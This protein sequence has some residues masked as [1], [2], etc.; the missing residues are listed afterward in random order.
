MGL[1][2]NLGKLSNMITSTG[3]A[4]SISGTLTLATTQYIGNLQFGT[5]SGAS[6]GYDAGS[7]AMTYNITAGAAATSTYY[8]FL[9][10]GTSIVNILKGGNVGIGVTPNAWYTGNSSKA[11]QIGVAGVG[12]WGYG[13]TTNINTYLT[14]NAYYDSVGW[15]YAQAS[16]KASFYQ[17][18]NGLHIWSTTDTTGTAAGDVISF[19]ERMRISSTGNVAIGDTATTYG[20][21][22][23]NGYGAANSLM[24]QPVLIA[25]SGANAVQLGSDG[26]NA[27][28]GAGNSGSSLI[29]LSRQ[30]GEYAAAITITGAGVINMNT[31]SGNKL[32]TVK[33]QTG[34]GYYG[35]VRMG[36]VDHSAGVIGRHISAG[37]ADLEFWTE[38]YSAGGY[39]KK[40]T[41]TSSGNIGAPTGTNI[42]NAS[43]ARFKQN[44]TTIED[45]IAKIIALNPVKFN[46]ID[47]FEPSED[48]KDM[49]G[50]I[51]QEVQNIIPEAVENFGNNSVTIGETIVE[52]PLRVNEKFII[53]VLVKAIQELNEKLIRNNIN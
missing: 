51:A 53:P 31:T 2:N 9:A 16:G 36:N 44:V 22:Y 43:D 27:L 24:T 10:D 45:G 46:W 14:N 5:A 20:K 33:G 52:N 28:I 26:T 17:Q 42:Y 7:G 23:V 32:V 4:V 29:L 19:T 15:K 34:N 13:S 8:N 6:I 40:M 39:T 49:L 1:T 37:N 25:S 48:G 12:I 30:S 3:S 35:E 38:A 47:G 11:L 18:N 50:F 41:I 21:L